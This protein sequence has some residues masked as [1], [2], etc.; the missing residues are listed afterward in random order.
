MM[1]TSNVV[2]S[3]FIIGAILFALVSVLSIVGMLIVDYYKDKQDTVTV[4]YDD[5]H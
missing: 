2:L 5:I 1:I 4:T 3:L